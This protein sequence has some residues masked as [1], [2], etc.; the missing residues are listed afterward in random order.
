MNNSKA[1]GIQNAHFS[2]ISVPGLICANKIRETTLYSLEGP[3]ESNY[4]KETTK[5]LGYFDKH[6][7][8]KMKPTHLSDPILCPGKLFHFR[9]F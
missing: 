5:N 8:F 3:L 7:K 2:K 1:N 9:F 4:S 6:L